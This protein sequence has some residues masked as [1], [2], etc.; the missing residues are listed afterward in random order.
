VEIRGTIDLVR[1]LVGR[2]VCEMH[3]STKSTGARLAF[4]VS[5][6]ASARANMSHSPYRSPG[7]EPPGAPQAQTTALVLIALI[8]P[9]V[10][11]AYAGR[12]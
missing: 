3:A 2:G 9:I 4:A 5:R 8:A 11:I 6:A 7:K 1:L 12:P 10:L